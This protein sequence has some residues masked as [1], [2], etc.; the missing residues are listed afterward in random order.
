MALLLITA[1]GTPAGAGSK[2]GHSRGN[3]DR[4]KPSVTIAHPTVGATISGTVDVDGTASDNVSVSKVEIQVDSGE[5]RP[6]TGSATWS[7]SLDTTMLADGTHT[8]S[9]RATDG[10]GNATVVSETVNVDNPA[11][12][13][14]PIPATSPTPTTSPSP[15]PTP[16]ASPTPFPTGGF[17]T[18]EGTVIKLNTA[19]SWTA[20]QVYQLLKGNGLDSRIGPTLTVFVQDTSVSGVT[21]TAGCCVDG[22]YDSFAA[23]MY[24]DGRPDSRMNA[25][26]NYTVGHEFGHVWTLYHLYMSQSGDWSKYLDLR[27]SSVDGSVKLGQDARLDSSYTWDKREIIADDYRLLF[28]S[29]LAVTESPTHLNP[30]IA[31]PRNV[32]GLKDFFAGTWTSKPA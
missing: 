3:S 16:T 9:A 1:R 21:A 19:S 18:P 6:V 5:L 20:D 14:A 27:W 30:Y 10:S 12:A 8:I 13:P 2:G 11:P 23:Y 29:T 15:S 28:G 22:R 32:T 24:L 31:D 17:V 25:Q 4:T 7:S 26:P